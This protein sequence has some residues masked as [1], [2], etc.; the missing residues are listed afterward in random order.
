MRRP[1]GIRPGR[2]PG[3]GARRLC[4]SQ[5][6]PSGQSPTCS[7]GFSARF[8][9]QA[10][11]WCA[12]SLQPAGCGWISGSPL[13]EG[14]AQVPGAQGQDTPPRAPARCSWL[15][16][17]WPLPAAGHSLPLLSALSFVEGPWP[18]ACPSVYGAEICCPGCHPHPSYRG[19]YIQKGLLCL[20]SLSHPLKAPAEGQAFAGGVPPRLTLS[21]PSCG[22]STDP[23]C[24]EHP[25]FSPT[26]T[27]RGCSCFWPG[28]GGGP[29]WALSVGPGRPAGRGQTL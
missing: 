12:E 3:A 24:S 14:T 26:L 4:G 19:S 1:Q 16:F 28:V 2:Q 27:L 8:Q 17:A 20:L 18:S 15:V 22:P 10:A 21:S 7:S 11:L 29:G 9:Q 25:D 6:L 5:G 23:H 13:L